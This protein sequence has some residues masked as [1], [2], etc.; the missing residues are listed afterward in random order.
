VNWLD[1]LINFV[2]PKKGAERLAYRNA[3]NLQATY[4]G[5][6]QSRISTYWSQ[7]ESITGLPHLN[8]QVHRYMRDRARSLIENNALA[9]SILNRATENIVGNGFQLQV[10]SSDTEWNKHC[11]ELFNQWFHH[12]DYYGR[13]WAQHQRLICNGLL[14]DGDIGAA[15]L[16]KGQIQL[17]EGDYISSPYTNGNAYLHDGVELDKFGRVNQYWIMQFVNLQNRTWKPIKPKDF[18]FIGN[19]RRATQYRGET[20][21]AQSFDLFDQLKGYLDAVV[22]SAKIAACL[23]IFIRQNSPTAALQGLGYG[24]N[25]GNQ[26]QRQLQLEPGMIQALQPGEDIQQINPQQPGGNFDNNVR[27]LIRLL[28]TNFGMPLEQVLLDFSQTNYSSARASILQAQRSFECIQKLLVDD[29]FRRVYRWRV[30]KFIND[31]LLEDRP[32]KFAH[33]WFAEEWPYLDPVKEIQASMLAVDAGLDTVRRQVMAK[34]LD[35]DKLLVERAAELNK[36]RQLDIPI[37]RTSLVA[38]LDASIPEGTSIDNNVPTP[39]PEE[40]EVN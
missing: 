23:A 10:L 24:R 19:I 39:T 12:A 8:L 21:F 31:G 11:E 25:A 22:L 16:G 6:N 9:S 14:R 5:A 27:M 30:S 7:S 13:T 38:Q 29:Y 40:I 26:S 32:D 37:Y 4:T 1:D 17:V 15:L 20:Y 35:P 28:G 18:I 36:M 34:G 2:S 33:R 3:N